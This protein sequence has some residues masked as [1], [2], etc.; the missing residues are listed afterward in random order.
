M[1][2]SAIIAAQSSGCLCPNRNFGLCNARGAQRN[3]FRQTSAATFAGLGP[4]SSATLA[5]LG[6]TAAAA[7]RSLRKSVLSCRWVVCNSARVSSARRSTPGA[8]SSRGSESRIVLAATG[9]LDGASV[10]IDFGTTNSAIA[11]RKGNGDIVVIPPPG[12]TAGKLT[13]PSA[14]AYHANGKFLVGYDALRVKPDGVNQ[15]VFRS[16]KRFMGRT[17]EEAHAAGID[18]NA[19]GA[20]PSGLKGELVRLRLPGNNG[21]MMPEEVAAHMIQYMVRFAEA[22]LGRPVRRAVMGVPVRFNK[23]Q[24][25][26]M[27]RAAQLI[28]I[29]SVRVEKEP[30]LAI[31]AYAY[32]VKP[33]AKE[34]FTSVF[35]ERIDPQMQSRNVLV[36]DL[37]G[38]TFDVTLVRNE[39]LTD[40]KKTV[41][42]IQVLGTSGDNRLGG[43]D[44]DNDLLDWAMKELRDHLEHHPDCLWPLTK[45]NRLRLKLALKKAKE[46]L[47]SKEV[48]DLDFAGAKLQLTRGEFNS[49]AAPTLQR[50]LPA[51][52]QACDGSGVKIP[53]ETLAVKTYEH[54]VKQEKERKA[55]KKNAEKKV[56][57]KRNKK[58]RGMQDTRLS[59]MANRLGVTQIADATEED[60]VVHGVLCVGAACWTPAVQELLEL[61]TG[62]KPSVTLINPE[63]AVVY[64]AAVLASMMDRGIPDVKIRSSF[65]G[66]MEEFLAKRPQL[67][68]RMTKT[69]KVAST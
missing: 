55:Y 31:R 65:Q 42:E 51:I 27:A 49:I 57:T 56:K 33:E 28:G 38:G 14:V 58:A 60:E 48:V 36:A 26:A 8:C 2:S 22:Y 69:G 32:K 12:K 23:Y 52:S 18:P 4:T 47:S 10:G 66:A 50:M 25:Y 54:K 41:D 35:E 64:G 34:T 40:E 20:D 3:R 53:F 39:L 9:E 19:Y 11:V 63:T 15:V 30:E 37:G 67:L 24:C 43:D 46:R 16:F 68:E 44:F 6:A 5:A 29:E 62:C 7:G 21:T 17:Y 61:M 13:F 59:S 1:D 45:L